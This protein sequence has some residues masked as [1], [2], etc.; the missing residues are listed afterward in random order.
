MSYDIPADHH[1][2]LPKLVDEPK[3]CGDKA[4]DTFMDTYKQF[5]LRGAEVPAHSRAG[6]NLPRDIALRAL[7]M[8]GLNT[9]AGEV[10]DVWK[11]YFFHGTNLDRDKL[12]LEL[13]DV[14]WYYTLALH[15]FG[16]TWDEI[17]AANVKKLTD[18]YPERHKLSR[19]V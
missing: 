11:K 1:G 9:E 5:V 4:V 7:A 2:P 15:V 12:R 16:F 8:T 10:G 3:M 18:R 19:K 13:G 14:L 6:T 17:I